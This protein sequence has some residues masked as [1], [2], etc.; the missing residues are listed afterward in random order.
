MALGAN[1][2]QGLKI[3]LLTIFFKLN[4]KFNFFKKNI[5]YS[6]KIKYKNKVFFFYPTDNSDLAV[7]E[8]IFYKNEYD[9]QLKTQPKIIFDLGGNVGLASIYFK[10]HFPNSKIYCFEPDPI[11]FK[12]LSDNIKQFKDI[13]VFN[14]AISNKTGKLNFYS[15]PDS[16]MSSSILS[17]DSSVAIEVEGSTLDDFIKKEGITN[18]DLIKFD[19]EGVEMEIF[20][21]F[22]NLSAVSNLIG[23]V[24]LDL[25]NSTLDDF[26]KLFPDYKKEIK[27]ISKNRRYSVFFFK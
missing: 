12:K 21:S 13:E 23:E 26:L 22:K 1:F 4:T 24:H 25:M 19:V 7:L 14:L 2:F 8:E 20:K 16:S 18:I 11:T 3:L 10:L 27:E 6:V 15:C 9:F 17:R 5:A